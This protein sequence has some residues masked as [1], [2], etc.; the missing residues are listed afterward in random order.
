MAAKTLVSKVVFPETTNHHNTMFAGKIMESMA[1]V[2][3]ITATKFSR[4]SFVM[5]SCNRINFS[6]PISKGKMIELRGEI[7]QIGRTSLMVDVVVYQEDM[8]F[9]GQVMAVNGE[10]VLVAIT[11]EGKPDMIV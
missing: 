8:L 1:E 10:F 7:K 5:A 9:F 3:F 11:D 6:K 2:A 4:Q